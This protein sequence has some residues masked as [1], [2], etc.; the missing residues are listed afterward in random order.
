MKKNLIST[1]V[2]SLG[3][4]E[5]ESLAIQSGFQIRKPRKI[6]PVALLHSY[7]LESINNSLSF[8]DISGVLGDYT[9]DLPSR[10]AVGKRINERFITFLEMILEK[11][12][13]EKTKTE[14]FSQVNSYFPRIIVQDST[15]VKLPLHLFNEF[16]GASNATVV[17]CHARIQGVYDLV[18]KKFLSFSIDKYSKND[19]DAASEL[20]VQSGDLVLRDR[21]YLKYDEVKRTQNNNAFF[22]FRHISSVKYRHPKTDEMIDLVELIKKNG[23]IDMDVCLNDKQRTPIRVV[24]APVSEETANL[25]RMKEK[26]KAKGHK[27]SKKLLFLMSWTIFITNLPRSEFDFKSILDLYGLRW[28]IETI[29]KTWKSNMS[30]A[31]IHRVSSQ[32]LRAMLM[33]RFITITITMHC[34]YERCGRIIS[35]HTD[36]NLS[37]SKLMRYI[38]VKKERLI[39]ILIELNENPV[40]VSILLSRF[41]AYDKRKRLNYVQIEAMTMK[42]IAL[43]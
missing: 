38:Q 41:C 34:V 31:T 19:C 43:S 24:S 16:S 28:R 15:V 7:C 30:F 39:E 22:I 25:R 1:A 37:M 29:F 33:A 23:Y 21:G 20:S 36:K 8:N 6:S 11:V 27:P 9:G 13:G 14:E 2:K 5:I 42:E 18:T 35:A 4:K 12:L 17:T 26:K 32:Q 40:E 3:L 10:Q